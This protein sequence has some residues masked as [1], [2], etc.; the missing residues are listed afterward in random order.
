[1]FLFIRRLTTVKMITPINSN[2]SHVLIYPAHQSAHLL[3][4]Q[5]SNTSHVLIYHQAM[6]E[7]NI[8]IEF[9]YI[10][11]SYLSYAETAMQMQQLQFKYI[12]CSYLSVK[13]TP[14]HPLRYV[15]KYI[16]CSYLS[17]P[18]KIASRSAIIQIHLMFLFIQRFIAFSISIILIFP[19]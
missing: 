17:S 1:M 4:W 18:V 10:S 9:K 7:L 15:F 13:F 11:C 14:F 2:T 6:P 19:S 5:H 16:S 8:A 12:S 3:L